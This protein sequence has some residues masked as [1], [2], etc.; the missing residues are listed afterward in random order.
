MK[1]KD[2]EVPEI[3]IPRGYEIDEILDMDEGGMGD[4]KPILREEGRYVLSDEDKKS[5]Y[6][7]LTPQRKRLFDKVMANFE[8][9]NSIWRQGWAVTGAPISAISGKKYNGINRMSLAVAAMEQGYS[10]NR[11]VTY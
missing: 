1:K 8:N 6:D 2:K 10:D 7:K 3:V 11:W 9:D 4:E 5:V